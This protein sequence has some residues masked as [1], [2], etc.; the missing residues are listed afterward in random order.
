MAPSDDKISFQRTVI[1]NLS[2]DQL[3]ANRRVIES[4]A[5]FR[6][7]ILRQAQD[8]ELFFCDI[9]R[10]ATVLSEIPWPDDSEKTGRHSAAAAAPSSGR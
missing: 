5:I 1:L 7:L 2:K 8:D 3:L 9:W 4:A 10:Q 6:G